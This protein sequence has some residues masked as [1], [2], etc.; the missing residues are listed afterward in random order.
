MTPDLRPAVGNAELAERA[1]PEQPQLGSPLVG[2]EALE[3]L[4]IWPFGQLYP[5][6]Q[7]IAPGCA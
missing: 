1:V 7:E 4:V 5:G 6:R 2:S 3:R